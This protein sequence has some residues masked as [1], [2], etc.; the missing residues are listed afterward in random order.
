MVFPGAE[1]AFIDGLKATGFLEAKSINIEWRWGE[2]QYN[3]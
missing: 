1:P 2:G 3:R